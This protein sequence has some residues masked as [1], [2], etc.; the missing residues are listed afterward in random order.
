MLASRFLKIVQ[1]TGQNSSAVS[2][3]QFLLPGTTLY[4]CQR[5]SAGP[6]RE[7]DCCAVGASITARCERGARH[8]A[9]KKHATGA[10][11]SASEEARQRESSPK[12]KKSVTMARSA[13]NSRY[14]ARTRDIVQEALSE[15]WLG[16]ACQCVALGRRVW[17]VWRG[18]EVVP[19]RTIKVTR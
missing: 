7:R 1:E 17:C 10:P 18:V 13:Q 12:N 11:H 6:R 9:S 5:V 19:R 14:C 16:A 2:T 8:S 15:A 3:C 4:L